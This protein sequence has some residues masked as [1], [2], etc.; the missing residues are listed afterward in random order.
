VSSRVKSE[1]IS[2]R[3]RV[4][5]SSAHLCPMQHMTLKKHA[6]FYGD[7]TIGGAVKNH[8]FSKLPVL[9]VNDLFLL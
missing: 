9:A 3:V 4:T 2:G 7:R 5:N 1:V 6:N 8:I